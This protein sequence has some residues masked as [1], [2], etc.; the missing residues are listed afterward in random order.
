MDDDVA[1]KI[2]DCPVCDEPFRV[3]GPNENS[4][5]CPNCAAGMPD[6]SVICLQCGYNNE[7]GDFLRTIVSQEKE[8]LPTW[9]KYLNSVADAVPGLFK[10]R[11]LIAAF[12]CFVVSG[13]MMIFGMILIFGLQ[14]VLSGTVLAAFGLV[15]YAQA[16]S[17]MLTGT[18]D[19]LS[20]AMGDFEN[21]HWWIF[22][23]LIFGPFLAI[24]L[25]FMYYGPKL[26]AQ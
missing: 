7:T 23:T 19:R 20:V 10:P 14:V 4:R 11:I 24:L 2:I 12:I 8:E 17:L 3:P 26:A 15:V 21:V 25:F 6:D 9:H 22:S 18:F 1:G 16:I 13:F 5:N